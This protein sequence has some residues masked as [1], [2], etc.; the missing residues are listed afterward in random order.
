MMEPY[1][2]EKMRSDLG[3]IGGA[4]H[5]F[6]DDKGI[7]HGGVR[8]PMGENELKK[9]L[10]LLALGEKRINLKEREFRAI[11]SEKKRRETQKK[12]FSRENWNVAEAGWTIQFKTADED[13]GGD[14]KYF[15]LWLER[16]G[17]N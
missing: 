12:F 3:E 4:G 5:F 7:Y 10:Q 17:K 14:G 6:G 15:H 11:L 1:L 9:V 16:K 13:Y 8:D 2:L